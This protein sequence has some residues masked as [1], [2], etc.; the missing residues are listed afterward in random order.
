MERRFFGVAHKMLVISN[1]S[2]IR[3]S[4]TPTLILLNI[5]IY[6]DLRSTAACYIIIFQMFL[7]VGLGHGEGLPA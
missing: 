7:S 1:I 5:V 4:E 6:K 2:K 3:V